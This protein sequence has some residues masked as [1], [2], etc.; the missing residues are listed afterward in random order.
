[1]HGN[2]SEWVLDQYIPDYYQQFAGKNTTRPL[3]VPTKLYPRVARG[4]CWDDDPDKLR[5]A[6][7]TASTKDWKMQDPQIPQSIWYNTEV[8]CPGFRVV[9]PLRVP[10]AEEAKLYEPDYEAIK[11]Y[12]EAQAGKM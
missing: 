5:S 7:R 9:R 11:E 3:A 8:F 2:V 4:G 1:M 6:A 12:K 10:G